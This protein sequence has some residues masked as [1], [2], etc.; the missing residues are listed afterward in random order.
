MKTLK[1]Y[2]KLIYRFAIL[3]HILQHHCMNLVYLITVSGV[4]NAEVYLEES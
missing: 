3:C 2:Q 1:N 4:L